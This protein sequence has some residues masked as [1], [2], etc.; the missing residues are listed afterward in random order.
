MPHQSCRYRTMQGQSAGKRKARQGKVA[1]V[2]RQQWA[3]G[4]APALDERPSSHC[5]G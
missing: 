3:K 4:L 5:S 1:K 2:P